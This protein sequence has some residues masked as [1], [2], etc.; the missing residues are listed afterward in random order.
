MTPSVYFSR[1]D[2]IG[3]ICDVGFREH[4]EI[5][6]YISE[7]EHPLSTQS[8]N[9]FNTFMVFVPPRET[10]TVFVPMTNLWNI[11]YKVWNIRS[12][13]CFC[14]LLN[15]LFSLLLIHHKTRDLL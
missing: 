11:Y 12:N 10:L 14:F 13:Y 4:T 7:I 6:H 8:K 15:L 5:R 2:A 1:R 3:R 9:P